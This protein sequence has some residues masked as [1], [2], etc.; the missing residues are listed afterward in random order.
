[1]TSFNP[2]P[3][4]RDIIEYPQI[5]LRV[6]AGAGTGKTTTIV[7]RLAAAV[8]AGGD[9]TRALG[10]TFTNKASDE[11]RLKLRLAVGDRSDGREVEVAT[12]HGFASS[13]LDEFGA[14]V[15]YEPSAALMDDGHRSELAASVLHSLDTTDL[16]LSSLP[17]RMEDLLAVSESLTSNLKQASNVVAIAP[18]SL[19]DVWVKRLALGEAAERFAREKERLGF[20]EYSDLIRLAVEIVEGFPDVASQISRRYDTV[21]LD[22][23]QDTDPAQRRLLTAVFA[24]G[25]AV[26]AVGDTD[27]TIYEWRGASLENFTD[28]PKHFPRADGI[29]T[30]TLPLSINRRSDQRILDLANE[31]QTLLPRLEASKP[32]APGPDSEDGIVE[33]GW[34]ATDHEEASWIADQIAVRHDAGVAWDDIAILC[35]KRTAIPVIVQ[36]LR[37][38]NIPYSVSSMGELLTI[39]EVADLLAW[40]RVLADP[41]DEP[42]LLRIWMSGLFRIGMHDISRVK[43]WCGHDDTRDLG[44]AMEHI[45]DIHGLSAGGREKLERFEELH[46]YLHKNAQVQSVPAT[47]SLTIEH[48]G[49]W[50]E[51]AALSPQMAA[52]ARVN[53]GRFTSIAQNWRALDGN[54]TL[55]AFLRYIVALNEAQSSENL[56]AAADLSDS[57]VQV[58]TA[59]SAKGLEWPVVFLPS[60][61]D[62]TFPSSVHTYDDPERIATALPYELRLDGN[63]FAT[64]AASTGTER[65]EILKKR[66]ADSEWRLAYVAVTRA[67]HDLVM[68]GHVWD[69]DVVTPRSPSPLLTI[70]HDLAGS[71][72]GPWAADPGGKKEPSPYVAAP[73]PPDPDFDPD[74]S[75]VLRD[76]VIDANWIANAYPDIVSAVDAKS[77]QLALQISDL[78]VTEA[79][80][81]VTRFTT[82]VTN[83]VA[84]AECPLKFKWIH[85]DRLPRRPGIAAKLGTEFHRKVELHNKGVVSLD[86]P[87]LMD[88]D[89][90]MDDAS[91][92]DGEPASRRVDPWPTFEGSRFATVR[93]RFAEVPF[94]LDVGQAA[95]RGKIDAIYGDEADTWEVVDYKS[96][97]R[98]DNE[99]RNVQLEV[100]ALAIHDGAVTAT[101]PDDL[102]VTFAYFGGGICEEVT[103]TVDEKWI[104]DARTHVETLVTTAEAGPF[105]PNPSPDCR[106]CD[107]LHLCPEGQAEVRSK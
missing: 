82:S 88:I 58:I 75:S 19:D 22:E 65:T 23:Y 95:V 39:P 2:T 47:V 85:H 31:I 86:D 20:F 50:D 13:I 55:A 30:E 25:V 56:E 42:S 57:V 106:H 52:T 84:L 9:P 76:R 44:V 79:Q 1:M 83:L 51:V 66:H 38:S 21:L 53:I 32:L 60:L 18:T 67:K 35:R 7:E 40:L 98:R 61:A 89:R 8:A 27:Q 103:S 10:I 48:L 17:K 45:A 11:L 54:P 64:A 37:D 3:E 77:N 12:Y 68:T 4:Q 24:H 97:R 41:S 62:K 70:A 16:D 99:A 14:F 81:P 105:D 92:V 28:F 59:H 36:K 96:G 73:L 93:A 33:V 80:Q 102:A 5:P 104:N 71:T 69:A 100:Y 90:R 29:A 101:V 43:R 49:F 34:F 15:G 87:S 74:W 26:T 78:R 91:P 63:S 72:K 6:V 94:T 107:F 46:S